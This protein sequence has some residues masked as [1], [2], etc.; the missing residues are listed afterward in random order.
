MS[1][2]SQP[3]S[4]NAI[5]P[6][7]RVSLNSLI[8]NLVLDADSGNSS[9]VVR[10]GSNTSFYI[11]KYSNVGVNTTSPGAQFEVASANGSCVRLRYGASS[12]AFANIFM[13]SLGNLSINPNTAGSEIVTS[14]S[15]N[16]SGH[17]GTST[18]LKLNGSLVTATAAQLNYNTVTAGTASNG[19][20]LVL[21]D[22]GSIT[23]ITS[24]G[25]SSITI[26]TSTLTG[27]Q[28]AYLTG[29]TAGSA[30]S[31][32]A[33]VLDA[34]GNI[35]GINLL[36]T[37]NL[38]VNGTDVTSS[39]A[40][41]GYVTNVT[42]G[43]A[44]A[45]KALIVNA[46][47]TINGI[48][49]IGTTSIT[50]SGST[51]ADEAAYLSGAVAGTAAAN[52]VL[53]LNSAKNIN[54]LNYINTTTLNIGGTSLI[55]TQADYLTGIT[56]GT[57][58]AGKALILD[59]NKDI[60]G[61]RT[62]GLSGTNTILN[63]S[64]TTASDFIEQTF[65][66]DTYSLKIGIRGSS[67]GTNPGMAYINYNNGY[68]LL[69]NS[70]GELAIGTTT[71]GYRLNIGGSVNATSYSLNGTS[72]D[73]T[74]IT[75]ITAGTAVA[76]KAV[77]LDGS[78]NITGIGS[79]T[80]TT[81]L[82]SIG[83]AS[84]TS[85][86][87]VGTLT[88]L[89]TSGAIS[90]TFNNNTVTNSSYQTWTNS[91][92]TALTVSLSMNNSSP[93]FGTTSNHKLRL[94]T[95]STDAVFIQSSGNVSIGS[96]VD[97][98]KLSVSGSVNATSYNLN[99]ASFDPTLITGITAGT[100]SASKAIILDGSKNITGIG[101]LTA[102]TVFGSISTA[103]QT[104]ITTV[105]TLTSLTTS[106]AVSTT[107]N[108]N[109]STSSGYHTWTN[110]LVTPITV[111]LLMN[112][113]SPSFGTTSNHKLRLQT[114]GADAVIVQSSGNVSIGSDVDTHKLSVA[115]SLNAT[116][117]NL[118]G[119]SFDPTL[120][121]G[122]T[123]GTASASKAVVLDG[124]KSITGIGSL[125][126]TTLNGTIGTASQ[127]SITTVG[128][129]T[130]LTTSG[131]ISTT[132]NNNTSTNSSY[133][134]WTN[135]L[136]TAMAV[137]LSM[138]NSSPSFGTASNHKLRFQT[139]GADVVH[140]QTSGNVSIG[141]DID[142]YKLSV[143]GTVNSTGYYL[144]GSLLDFSSSAYVSGIT[145]GTAAASK[146]LVTDSNIAISGMGNIKFASTG[147]PFV[148][149]SELGGGSY[150]G[151]W[152][153]SNRWGIGQHTSGSSQ[154]VRIGGCN[155]DGSWNT[156]YPIVYSGTFSAMSDYRL[157]YNYRNIPFGLETVN[158]LKPLM[159]DMVYDDRTDQLGFIA[160]EV[161][162]VIPSVVAG[163]KDEVD[164]YGNEVHQSIQYVG[165][166]P[167]AIKAIQELSAKVTELEI[168][169]VELK[170]Q[171]DKSNSSDMNQ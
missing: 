123:A 61:I 52:K 65:T 85:I 84:Q 1:S 81:L 25:V 165:L 54:G 153:A 115:G 87:A 107:I 41:S 22:T 138:N 19:K 49:A 169:I 119:S 82:G 164:K 152:G 95:N 108:N 53:V 20:A 120:I 79:L 86:T 69:I 55:S 51:I 159:Y 125:T 15:L 161:Q 33:L 38:V 147:R 148:E 66:S 155:T 6:L 43:A 73:P 127:T 109:T 166:I 17:N 36:N 111:G 70:T 13:T 103:S 160:H 62:L 26:N 47:K 110:S 146:A 100:A 7:Q 135:S 137:S 63:L 168:T 132:I 90:T 71:F 133:Q 48:T 39:L 98:H 3:L 92:S 154:A 143:N 112:N 96:D 93:S 171:L 50:V 42:P 8:T 46:D 24:L 150:I 77:I 157:K 128:T 74:S 114:N 67:N 58:L 131:A 156:T 117:Y 151:N 28:A 136:S 97:T 12:T 5:P 140:I 14:A 104:S 35:A 134:T 2:N 144:N 21:G 10:T 57:G 99:G 89:A 56:T 105:G 30:L 78:K 139:N 162:E 9:L 83:T 116:S 23:G 37:A 142:S 130:S 60:T 11:D 124:T 75:G 126:A 106:G 101:S 163:V 45:N 59:A 122:I 18:G 32:K 113:S 94:Q 88:S 149:G 167:V 40:A 91:L 44:T 145:P 27:T 102:T 64:N 158:R 4:G 141:S 129:L 121:T 118:N 16:L 72:F 76:S 170:R 34:S 68:R 29:I 80:A 31:G